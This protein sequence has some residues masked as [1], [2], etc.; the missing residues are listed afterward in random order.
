MA[1]SYDVSTVLKFIE[2]KLGENV[3]KSPL[4]G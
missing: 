2:Q 1:M 4:C 3:F